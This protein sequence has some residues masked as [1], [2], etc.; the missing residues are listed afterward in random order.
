MS[1]CLQQCLGMH[2]LCPAGQL[3][4]QCVAAARFVQFLYGLMMG[5][6]PSKALFDMCTVQLPSC[7]LVFAGEQSMQLP[8]QSNCHSVLLALLLLL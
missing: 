4:L 2:L 6:Q 1:D 8:Q 5:M 7:A 3:L